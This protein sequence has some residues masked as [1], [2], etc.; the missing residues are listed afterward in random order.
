MFLQAGLP[1][2]A[3]RTT[4]KLLFIN[5]VFQIFMRICR[6]VRGWRDI[7]PATDKISI[8]RCKLRNRSMEMKWQS[9][10]RCSE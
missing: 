6:V 9:S 2:K 10:G 5:R 3:V 4:N 8:E 1:A 7:L